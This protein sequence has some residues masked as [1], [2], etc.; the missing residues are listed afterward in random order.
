MTSLSVVSRLA[1]AAAA[2]AV[3]TGSGALLAAP[4]FQNPEILIEQEMGSNPIPDRTRPK[5]RVTG[6]GS[7]PQAVIVGHLGVSA[8]GT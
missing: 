1:A 7:P 3:L 4:R 8:Y 2:T 5:V 6:D